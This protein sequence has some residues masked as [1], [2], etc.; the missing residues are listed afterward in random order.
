MRKLY[1]LAVVGAIG[2][3]G[4]QGVIVMWPE[5]SAWTWWGIAVALIPLLAGPKIY[6]YRRDIWRLASRVT[7]KGRSGG[8]PRN[9]IPLIDGIDIAWTRIRKESGSL[10]KAGFEGR[11]ISHFFTNEMFDGSEDSVAVYAVRPPLKT[12]EEISDIHTFNIDYDKQTAL[13]SWDPENNI[14]NLQVRRSDVRK[15]VKN[16]L[17]RL[18][19]EITRMTS[20]ET[21][22]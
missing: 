5:W 12:P 7:L 3:A 9:L 16:Y 4:G 10:Q 1:Y 21:D 8:L 11:L 6:D 20:D 15:W 2:F 19:E 18:D 14:K 17:R 22:A 13:H